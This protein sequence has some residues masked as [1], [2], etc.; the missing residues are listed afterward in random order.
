M[1]IV[2]GAMF[3][4]LTIAIAG[5]AGDRHRPSRRGHRPRPDRLVHPLQHDH[6]QL[7]P[8]LGA[9]RLGLHALPAGR[10]PTARS[11]FWWTV[12]GLTLAAGWIEI[13][14]LLVADKATEAGAV[15]TIN[16]ILSGTPLAAL[17]MIAIGIG[18]VAVNAMNDYTGSLSLQAAGIRVPRVVLGD[19]RRRPRLRGHALAE[20]GEPRRQDREHPPV[21]EL[22]DRAVGGR[23]PGRL[24]D[25]RR[26]RRR[27]PARE[28]QRAAERRRS[29]CVAAVIGFLVS[30]PFQTSTLG[31]EIAKNT[32]LPINT[33]AANNLHYADLAYV[34]GFVVAF[35][36]YL[37]RGAMREPATAE[38]EPTP[39]D[40]AADG[41]GSSPTAPSH[42]AAA[43]QSGR[44]G[45]RWTTGSRPS[46]ADVGG[47]LRRG[48]DP[49][50]VD[51]LG[52]RDQLLEGGGP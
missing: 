31:G 2:L 24:A 34:V 39:P 51:L 29:R 40:P 4:V 41:R 22:L 5:Q 8:G 52:P 49:Q 36:I 9:L 27:E 35:A 26:P 15:D 43:R 21:P 30:L 46:V 45:R 6:R 3:V 10:P 14:G 33:I 48:R 11:V 16:S 23:R 20:L 17:A 47:D 19:R 37:G 25:A 38:P 32:G 28:L 7:R 18:T 13:L 1:A 12:L 44:T 42:V 50:A